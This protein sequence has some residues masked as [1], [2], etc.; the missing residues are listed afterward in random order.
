MAQ[1]AKVI[2]LTRTYVPVD[3]QNFPNNL[4]GTQKEDYPEKGFPIVAY[5]GYNFLPTAYGYKSFFGTT[6]KFDIEPVPARLDKLL[7]FEASTYKN[8]IIALT[9]EGI[10]T[11]TGLASDEWVHTVVLA[12]PEEGTHRN[13]TFCVIANVLYMYRAQEASYWTVEHDTV[14]GASAV[15]PTFLN[16]EGQRGI[17]KAGGRLGIWDSEGSIAWSNLDDHA[18]FEPSLET[19]AGAAIFNEVRGKITTIKSFGDGFIIYAT[20]SI[21]K[22]NRDLAAT[23]QWS[24]KVLLSGN[25]VAYP[26]QVAETSP[27]TTQYAYT[28]IGMLKIEDNKSE[29]VV[30]EVTDLLQESLYPVMLRVLENR[31]LAFQ[32]IEAKFVEGLVQFEAF[33]NPASDYVFSMSDTANLSNA[34]VSAIYS[35]G[36]FQEQQELALQAI[37]NAGAPAIKDGTKATAVWRFQYFRRTSYPSDA[38]IEGGGIIWPSPFTSYGIRTRRPSYS[39]TPTLTH[40]GGAAV[41]EIPSTEITSYIP[42]MMSYIDDPIDGS[43]LRKGA[44]AFFN[45]V[46]NQQLMWNED[47]LKAEAFF[48]KYKANRYPDTTANYSAANESATAPISVITAHTAA[49]ISIGPCSAGISI[50]FGD[51][52]WIARIVRRT[53]DTPNPDGTYP[54]SITHD[55]ILGEC[56]D[57]GNSRTLVPDTDDLPTIVSWEYEGIDGEMHEVDASVCS[58][59]ADSGYIQPMQIPPSNFSNDGSN[60]YPWNTDPLDTPDVT[61]TLQDG[62]PGPIYPTYAGALIYDTLLQKWGKMKLDYT[63]LLDLS[64]INTNQGKIVTTKRFGIDAAASLPNGLIHRFDQKPTDSY[65]KYGKIGFSRLGMTDVEEVRVQFRTPSTGTIE[66]ESSLDGRNPEAGFSHFSEYSG[67]THAIAFPNLSGRW[68]NIT[69]R[70]NYDLTHLEFRGKTAG[71]R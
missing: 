39:V 64:P 24:P 10:F 65:I 55:T 20:N 18:D 37:Q 54:Y 47:T 23:F 21:V 25:G 43:Y 12:A 50:T 68:H 7:I 6:G 19:L 30:T 59:S 67:A 14:G 48:N 42:S 71:R 26:D 58:E 9:E 27:D 38:A 17:F 53:S 49:T 66:V 15:T 45:F 35:L 28:S 8:Y 22:V 36:Y 11:H 52:K 60:P 69:L 3:P 56:I 57:G 62:D 33:T 63:Q 2:D 13:W 31:Y 44:D 46:K 5:E 51:C 41:T 61:I 40:T 70:G 34:V 16:M 4:H 29:P 1:Y 32:L